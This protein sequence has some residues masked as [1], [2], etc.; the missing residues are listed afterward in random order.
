MQCESNVGVYTDHNNI[1]TATLIGSNSNYNS[2]VPRPFPAFFN[3]AGSN[4][5][6]GTVGKRRQLTV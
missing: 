5:G 2:Q 4:A 1:Q 3:V 6:S